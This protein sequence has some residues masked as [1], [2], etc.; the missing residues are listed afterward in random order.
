MSKTERNQ[1]VLIEQLKRTPIVQLACEKS[2]ISR[3]TY[4]RWRKESE[5]FAHAADTALTESVALMNDMAESQLLSSIRDGNLTGIIFW[6]KNRHQAYTT[7]VQIDA[8]H[9]VLEEKLTPEQ[10]QVVEEALRLSGIT[11]ETNNED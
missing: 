4:Y 9:R 3:A 8:T 2:G 10:Q 7:R 5:E 11:Q 6:L 1:G